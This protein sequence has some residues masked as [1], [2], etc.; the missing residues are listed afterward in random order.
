MLGPFGCFF[1]GPDGAPSLEPAKALVDLLGSDLALMLVSGRTE[2]QLLDACHVF[3]ADGFVGEL[4]A[5]IGHEHGREVDL[6][7][8]EMPEHYDGTPVEVLEREGVVSALLDRYRGRLEF[9]APWHAGHV[10]DLM[11]RGH[12][13][14]PEVEAWLSDEGFGWLRVHDN[15]VLPYREM[16]GVTGAVHVY[17]VMPG[18]LTKGAGVAADLARR[19]LSPNDAIAVGDSI[20]DLSMAPHVRRF[21][22]TANGAAS[23]PTKE[24]A[25]AY[26]NLTICDQA[27]GHGW[28]QA[29]RWALSEMSD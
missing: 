14:P 26:D 7:R 18:G 12:V 21:F 16:D 23:P 10:A 13:D 1:R 27:N 9:H 25:A 8:G 5:V 4:G 3:G 29:V 28:L 19:G 6:L 15:G 24:A 11:L 17:H 22:L 20:S 2:P